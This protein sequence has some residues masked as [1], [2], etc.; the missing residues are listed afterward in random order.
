M[1][2][3]TYSI[4]KWLFKEGTGLP[5]PWFLELRDMIDHLLDSYFREAQSGKGSAGEEKT[6]PWAHALYKAPYG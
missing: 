5:E 6:K 4:K 3:C 1:Q 2:T